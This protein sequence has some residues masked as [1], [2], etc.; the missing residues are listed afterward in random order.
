MIMLRIRDLDTSYHF[1]SLKVVCQSVNLAP[2][3]ERQEN[4]AI[5]LLWTVLLSIFA[6]IS[7]FKIV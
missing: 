1:L 3:T 4:N 7:L 6:Q 5:T 2:V